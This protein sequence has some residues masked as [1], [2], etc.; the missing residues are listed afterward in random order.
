MRVIEV[1]IGETA[2]LK[3]TQRGALLFGLLVRATG[4][5]SPEPG[6]LKISCLV[7]AKNLF[8]RIFRT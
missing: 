2:L 6:N 8:I 7:R 5:T 3:D 4:W 1:F